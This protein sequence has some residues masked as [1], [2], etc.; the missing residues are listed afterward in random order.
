MDPQANDWNDERTDPADWNRRA[1]WR[2]R[3]ARRELRH[4]QS[5]IRV[6]LAVLAAG[7][8]LLGLGW[9]FE[10]PL[11][12]PASLLPPLLAEPVQIPINEPP[13]KATVDGV[14]YYLRPRYSYDIA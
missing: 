1:R 2:A 4:R 13:F 9:I 8:A 6:A 7:I 10:D 12:A 3:S 14:D 5:L 11:P